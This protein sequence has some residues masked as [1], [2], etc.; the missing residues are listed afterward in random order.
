E[1][2]GARAD[3]GFLAV[4]GPPGDANAGLP[5]DHLRVGIR[6]VL[7]GDDELAIRGDGGSGVGS[8]GKGG[9]QTREAVCAAAWVGVVLQAQVE[10]NGEPVGGLP[11]VGDIAAHGVEADVLFRRPGKGLVQGR[12]GAASVK[13]VRQIGGDGA[14][15]GATD[16]FKIESRDVGV[17]PA[18][19]G[20][21]GVF[22][23][24][25][26]KII[27]DLV[28]EDAPALRIEKGS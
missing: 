9:S 15:D 5:D 28:L 8:A 27:D 13:E 19:T 22:P 16:T 4:G 25:M 24:N 10:G 26:G 12:I 17:K 20:P 14:V 2:S 1:D 23:V 7:A 6:V 21:E 3:D 11:I 18:I